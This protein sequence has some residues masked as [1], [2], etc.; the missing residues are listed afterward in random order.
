MSTYTIKEEHIDNYVNREVHRNIIMTGSIM[1]GFVLLMFFFTYSYGVHGIIM[2]P[3]SIMMTVI[4]L[5]IYMA[6]FNQIGNIARKTTFYISEERVSKKL[7]TD[8]LNYINQFAQARNESRYGVKA[9][10]SFPIKQIESTV[11]KENEIIIKNYDYNIFN[12]NGKI[13]IP[14]EMESFQTVKK[15]ILEHKAKFKV[16]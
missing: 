5:F 4:L 13:V 15:F 10:Q 12:G 11:I 8:E 16:S 2:L 9:N 14:K 1:A 6:S 3:F 7:A